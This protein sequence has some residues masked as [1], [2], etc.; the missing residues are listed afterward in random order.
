VARLALAR[1]RS[2]AAALVAVLAVAVGGCGGGDRPRATPADGVRAAVRAYLGALARHDFAG[3][4]RRM[5]R[6][7]RSDLADA[8]GAPCAKALAAGAAEAAEDLAS[9]Q[10]EVAGADVRIRGAAASLGPLG[11][12][13]RALRLRRVGG[14]WLVAG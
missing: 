1:R 11:A 13:Q 6:A 3:A 2:I 8:A 10:R 4:C 12:A 5:T 7:A 14:R 9:A